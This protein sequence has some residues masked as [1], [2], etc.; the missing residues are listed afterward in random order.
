M[1]NKWYPG[2]LFVKEGVQY[3]TTCALMKRFPEGEFDERAILDRFNWS[4][5]TGAPLDDN[6]PGPAHIPAPTSP[7]DEDSS[8]APTA[9]TDE[10]SSPPQPQPLP[11]TPAAKPRKPTKPLPAPQRRS[12]RTRNPAN[13]EADPNPNTRK[14]RTTAEEFITDVDALEKKAA[15]EKISVFKL[16]GRKGP[17]SHYT[18]M[19][20]IA[21]LAR[22]DGP[23]VDG[24]IREIDSFIKLSDKCR[25]IYKAEH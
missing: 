21:K 14:R 13:E 16:L 20:N 12:K 9:P 7:T 6:I 25:E 10:D 15:D 8:P 2:G 5:D 23:K 22:V 1:R 4:P 19:R 17:Y 24:L 11:P 18:R 3:C